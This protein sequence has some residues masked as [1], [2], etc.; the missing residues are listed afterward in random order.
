MG[1]CHPL[2]WS[3]WTGT[4]MELRWF[5][6][7]AFCFALSCTNVRSFAQVE[8]HYGP[9]NKRHCKDRNEHLKYTF[10]HWLISKENV[11]LFGSHNMLQMGR[12]WISIAKPSMCCQCVTFLHSV[13]SYKLYPFSGTLELSIEMWSDGPTKPILLH[14]RHTKS[15]E[16]NEY[17][18]ILNTSA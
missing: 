16:V 15:Y 11:L 1:N 9:M 14:H 6:Y 7:F 5:Q 10:S 17:C 3:A 2:G 4:E 18:L 8:S 13:G 12:M